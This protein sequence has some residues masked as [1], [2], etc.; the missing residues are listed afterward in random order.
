M[1]TISATDAKNQLAGVMEKAIKEPV[2]I[3]KN[4][5]PF[6]VMMSVAEYEKKAADD[7]KQAFT[8]LCQELA[9]TA[10]KSGMTGEILQSILA[11]E[12]K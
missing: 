3:E 12:D 7:R 6:V 11:D 9:A 5:R 10:K 8:K 4:G 2:M 1:Q